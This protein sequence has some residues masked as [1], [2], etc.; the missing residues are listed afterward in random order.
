MPQ[1]PSPAAQVPQMAKQLANSLQ[2][3]KSELLGGSTSGPAGSRGGPSGQAGRP[4]QETEE[5]VGL[6]AE[7]ALQL[8]DRW[9]MIC[10]GKCP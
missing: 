1:D 4:A 9:V 6:D 7:G 8:Q 3:D 2:S 5:T 10:F